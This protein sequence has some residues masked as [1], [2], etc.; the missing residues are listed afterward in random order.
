MKNLAPSLYL[1]TR[2][3]NIESKASRKRVEN[4]GFFPSTRISLGRNSS[5]QSA[6]DRVRALIAEVPPM[7]ETGTNTA[8]NT[9][10]EVTMADEMPLMASIDALQG[11]RYPSSNRTCTAST[12]I[13]ASST[14]VPIAST[15]AKRVSRLMLNP[16]R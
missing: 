2:R 15:R 3:L 14:I 1:N 4:S 6:G 7:N 12:T 9:S 8:M 10:V 16:A 11:E 13:M 5:A